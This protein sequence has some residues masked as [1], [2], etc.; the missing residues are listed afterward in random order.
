MSQRSRIEE[1]AADIENILTTFFADKKFPLDDGCY[2]YIMLLSQRIVAIEEGGE[3]FC[4]MEYED[5]GN[6]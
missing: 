1:R 3:D 4:E 2:A 6:V 5:E